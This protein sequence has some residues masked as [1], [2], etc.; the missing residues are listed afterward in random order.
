MAKLQ[1][2]RGMNDILPDQTPSWQYLEDTFR[3][4]VHAYGYREIRFPVLEHTALFK[5]SIGEVTDIVEKEMYS[6]D[7][8]NGDNLSLRPEGTAGCV[9]AADQHGLLYNQQQRLWYQ[10]PMFRHERPQKG[11]YRQFHQF[12]VE[13]FGMSGPDIDFE[14]ISLATTLWQALELTEFLTLE[15]NNI[16]SARDRQSYASALT[17]YLAQHEAA[18]DDDAKQRL[19]TNPMRVLDSKNPS[20][21]EILGDAPNLADYVSVESVEHFEALL[22]LLDG[23]GISYKINPRLVRGLDYYNY[24]VFEWTT[25]TLG[26]QGAVC[27]GGRYDGLVEQ[28]GGKPTLAAGFAIGVE[29]LVLMLDELGKVPVAWQHPVDVYLVTVGASV[30]GQA[31]AMAAS[32]RAENPHLGVLCHCGGGK[33]NAQLKRAYAQNARLAVILERQDES[34]APLDEV[35]IRVLDDTGETM[36]VSADAVPFEVARLLADA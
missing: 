30:A 17:D 22:K 18:L 32:L 36:T 14:V 3:K 16:G 27:G 15:I 2:I 11:R 10:G 13:A 26:A 35:K 7:D 4:V 5:R 31:S 24:G 25:D 6:F 33:Y 20:V 8:R 9:R 21:Q 23:A 12:G 29:R 34:E 1:A 19:H 28:L